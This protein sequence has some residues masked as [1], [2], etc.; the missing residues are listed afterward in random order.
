[1]KKLIL[2]GITILFSISIAYPQACTPEWSQP[3][4]GIYPD[5]A[6]NMPAGP[7][8][9]PYDFTVQFKVPLKDSSVIATGIDVNRVELTG[10]TGL[11]AIPSTVAFH[12][13][14]N[15]TN[16]TFKADSV[17]CVRIQ[18]TPTT[19]GVYPLTISAK[20]FITQNTFLPVDFSGYYITVSNSIGI[21]GLSTN[22]FDVGQNTP[23]PAQSKTEIPVNLVHGSMIEIK[24]SNV[25]GNQVYKNSM[26][27]HT[28]LNSISLDVSKF[29]PG[30]YFY[31]VSDEK[32]AITRRMVIDK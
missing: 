25:I 1:M 30:I 29:K 7:A 15:P 23:N 22:R 10:V 14:C 13:N 26:V 6:T 28:G 20:V 18:G 9:V 11:D 31:T 2:C 16:C 24:V 32:N 5:T 4:S 12:Y 8:N 3:G 27:G 17:G 19:E 21:P